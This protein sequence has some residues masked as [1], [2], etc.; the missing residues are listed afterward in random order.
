M[1]SGDNTLYFCQLS[2]YFIA[3]VINMPKITVLKE[4]NEEFRIFVDGNDLSEKLDALREFSIKTSA[5]LEL[6][7]LCKV[8]EIFEIF[9]AFI[10][11]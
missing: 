1:S 5:S 3:E 2:R 8:K 10:M 4:E 11:F 7:G 9:D 6:L